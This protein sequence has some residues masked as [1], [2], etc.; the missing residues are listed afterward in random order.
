MTNTI[1]Y[2]YQNLPTTL[3]PFPSDWTTNFQVQV[4]QPLLQG[5]GVEFNRIAGPNG[6][7][8]VY[9]G[10]VLRGSTR[11]SPWPPS[12]A[13]CE[14]S[15]STWKRP[16]GNSTSP[17]GTSTRSIVGRNAALE[18]W[19]KIHALYV[20]SAK[21]GEADKEFQAREQYYL[22]RS[23][24]ET[25]LAGLYSTESKLR[26][27]MGLAASDGRLIRPKDEPTTAKVTFDWADTHAE[28]LCRSV[29]LRQQRWKVKQR[30]M[31]LVAAKNYLLPRLDAVASYTWNGMD[32]EQLGAENNAFGAYQNLLHGDFQSWHLGFQ[33]TVPIGFRKEMSAVRNAE[34]LLAREKAKLQ[35]EELEVSHQ[36]A[37]AMRD[38][39][40]DLMIAQTNFNRCLAAQREVDAVRAAYEAGQIILDVLLEA[41]RSLADAQSAYYRVLVNYNVAIA[42]VHYRKGSL[43]EYNGV[44]S[45]GGAVAGEGVFRRPPPRPRPR[46][47]PLHQLRLHPARARQPRAVEP[48]GRRSAHRRSARQPGAGDPRDQQG[49]QAGGCPG[50]RADAQLDAERGARRSR[51]RS[52]PR[53]RRQ[54][55]RSR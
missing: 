54:E 52:R 13:R 42:Q 49:S 26:Y 40:S 1:A 50:A 47:R 28:A 9:N 16:T 44:C 4:R 8:G 34:L 36:V 43:L 5:A 11:T 21:G 15:S 7:P 48:A 10:V 17:T 22:F 41:Q 29:E 39:E 23:S 27:L 31:Q 30:E 20:V 33:A 14:T 32:Q 55:D 25:A 19:R 38:M 6:Q 51:S 35:E 12:R 18:T 53:G 3:R 46:R 45:G 24:V 37:Y 2:D